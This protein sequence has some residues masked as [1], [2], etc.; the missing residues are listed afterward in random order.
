MAK[1][2][3]AQKSFKDLETEL[4]SIITQLES[5]DVPLEEAIAAFEAGNL[6]L[7]EAQGRLDAAEQ[8]VRIL[9]GDADED[10]DL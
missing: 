10:S 1:K 6:L 5:S 2:E 9:T 4:Q 3:S 7:K 8:K